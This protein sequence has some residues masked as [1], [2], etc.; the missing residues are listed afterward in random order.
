M[1]IIEAMEKA[2]ESGGSFW[3]PCDLPLPSAYLLAEDLLADN[4]QAVPCF[5]I[6]WEGKPATGGG[7]GASAE[8][9]TVGNNGTNALAH[10][11][12]YQRQMAVGSADEGQLFV[13][14]F[15]EDWQARNEGPMVMMP[16]PGQTGG[17]GG[18]R[19]KGA[20]ETFV[21][22]VAKFANAP[23]LVEAFRM[24][25]NAPVPDPTVCLVCGKNPCVCPTES[26]TM[27]LCVKPVDFASPLGLLYWFPN[28]G[29][30]EEPC[31][32]DQVI[33]GE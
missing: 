11:A 6:N 26:E 21:G 1:N 19:D 2:K 18:A 32:P 29:E 33:G 9:V 3:R 5:Q 20:L 31:E 23:E 13:N 25:M 30:P 14:K 24:A 17:A 12:Q 27:E 15:V 4:W 28:A 22:M 7:G 16:V 8:T 10:Q